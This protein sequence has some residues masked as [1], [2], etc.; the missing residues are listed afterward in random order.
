MGGGNY[1]IASLY[2]RHIYRVSFDERF[3]KVKYIEKIYIGERIRDLKYYDNLIFLALEE[4]NSI[5]V[6]KL[7]TDDK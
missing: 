7:K 4:S 3:T 6:I 2:S 1:L 5:G